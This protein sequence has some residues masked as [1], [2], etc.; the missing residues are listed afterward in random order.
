MPPW[1]LA[2]RCKDS[3]ATIA[4]TCPPCTLTA[5]CAAYSLACSHARSLAGSAAMGVHCPCSR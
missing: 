3:L 1:A 2:I 4:R 5:V